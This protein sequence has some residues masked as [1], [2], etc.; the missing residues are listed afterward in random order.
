MTFGSYGSET[1]SLVDETLLSCVAFW[2]F[3]G[4][5]I[6]CVCVLG[7]FFIVLYEFRV[8]DQQQ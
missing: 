2:L 6:L 3:G 5:R 7:V 8:F 1:P 4:V